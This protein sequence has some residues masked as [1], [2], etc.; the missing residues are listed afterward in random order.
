VGAISEGG[1]LEFEL[2][3]PLEVGYPGREG[4]ALR[5]GVQ[6]AG[7]L[8]PYAPAAGQAGCRRTRAR[9]GMPGRPTTCQPCALQVMYV[10]TMFNL[11]KYA[12]LVPLVFDCRLGRP[13]VVIALA[14]YAIYQVVYMLAVLGVV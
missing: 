8:L 5:L 6:R 11:I 4:L 7:P 12:L 9:A 2:D 10:F 1:T 13:I 14:Y 3:K